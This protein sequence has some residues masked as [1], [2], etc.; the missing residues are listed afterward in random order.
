MRKGI[1]P[2][3]LASFKPHP[4]MNPIELMIPIIATSI[5]DSA[6]M[7]LERTCKQW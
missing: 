2:T 1:V 4:D 3:T 7:G 6:T 5:P